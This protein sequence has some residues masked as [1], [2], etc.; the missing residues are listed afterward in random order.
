ML[1]NLLAKC[2]SPLVGYGISHLLPV[3]SEGH[4]GMLLQFEVLQQHVHDSQCL[5]QK[6]PPSLSASPATTSE[7]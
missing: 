2:H 7:A 3:W 6:P 5:L 4:G 1:L